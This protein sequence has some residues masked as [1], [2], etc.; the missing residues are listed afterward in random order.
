[1]RVGTRIWGGEIE[2]PSSTRR[3]HS[4]VEATVLKVAACHFHGS[5]TGNW[6]SILKNGIYIASG[7]EFMS[8]GAAL[9]DGAYFGREFITSLG[10][11]R[12]HPIAPL[13]PVAAG[14]LLS[15]TVVAIAE[16]QPGNS[17]NMQQASTGGVLDFG[18]ALVAKRAD[19]VKM[20]CELLPPPPFAL[21]FFRGSLSHTFAKIYPRADLIVT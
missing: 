4:V 8:A 15:A 5:H 12:T 16:L 6:F 19:L 17:E 1:M 3:A 14:A 9:G 10:Y 2:V 7:T 13:G 20:K 18:W 11:A 21:L